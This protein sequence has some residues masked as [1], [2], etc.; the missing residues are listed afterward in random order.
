MMSP[1]QPLKPMNSVPSWKKSWSLKHRLH[2][3]RRRSSKAQR[4]F[5]RRGLVQR[6]FEFLEPRAMMALTFQFNFVKNEAGVGFDNPDTELV[7]T[8]TAALNAA[9]ATFGSWFTQ[10]ATLTIDVQDFHDGPLDSDG[11]PI[12][13]VLNTDPG[14]VRT[15]PERKV[16]LGEDLN[17]ADADGILYLNWEEGNPDVGATSARWNYTDEVGANEM[18]FKGEVLHNLAHILGFRSQITQAGE[19]IFFDPLIH[20]PGEPG[21]W[22]T[23]DTFLSDSPL[24]EG[25][26]L[27][28]PTTFRLDLTRWGAAMIGGNSENTGL[29]FHGP[30]A[31]E[32]NG[33][34]PVPLLS[35]DP[36]FPGATGSHLRPTAT[37]N[38][39]N[40]MMMAPDMPGAQ[41]LGLQARRFTP[42]EVGMM[43]DLGYV[44][45]TTSP[46][47]TL[48]TTR[49]SPTP[50]TSA[51][52][53]SVDFGEAVMGSLS[54][55]DIE[56]INATVSNVVQAGTLFRFTV[57]PTVANG[58]V[59]LRIPG[60]AM[61]DTAGNLSLASDPLMIVIDSTAPS[62]VLS[63]GAVSPT[64]SLGAFSVS[65]N[66]SESLPQNMT[67]GQISVS[68]GVVSDLQQAGN[69]VTF[70]VTPSTAN[71][72]VSVVVP[73]E[74]LTDAAGNKNVA[75]NTISVVIDTTRPTPVFV[76]P[77]TSSSEPKVTLTVNFGETVGDFLIDPPVT[78]T[79]G[80]VS[81]FA[82]VTL[83]GIP[84]SG[85]T[86]DVTPDTP[87]STVVVSV[88]ADAIDD[89]AGN[90]NVGSATPATI[91]FGAATTSQISGRV[92]VDDNENGL[93]NV[94]ERTLGGVTVE[95]FG[96]T[97]GLR[98]RIVTLA[99]GSYRFLN[100]PQGE[101]RVQFSVPEFY[102]D[103]PGPNQRM[104]TITAPG[105]QI[106]GQDFALLGLSPGYGSVLENLA[107][108]FYR[109]DASLRTRG[110]VAVVKADGS[111]G[112]IAIVG[113]FDGV[114]AVELVLSDDRSTAYVTF[115]TANLEV[116][117]ATVDR[118]KLVSITDPSGNRLIRLLGGISDLTFTSVN[119]DAPPVG[120]ARKYFESIEKVFEQE[121]WGT[122]GSNPSTTVAPVIVVSKNGQTPT[123]L[124]VTASGTSTE[125]DVVLNAAPV[126]GVVVLNVQ[127]ANTNHLQITSP[128]GAGTLTFTAANWNIPQKV[129][130]QGKH[131]GSS[132]V[133]NQVTSVAIGV[134]ASLTTATN[135]RSTLPQSVQVTTIDDMGSGV[136]IAT[137]KGSAGEGLSIGGAIVPLSGFTETP[138]QAALAAGDVTGDGV[139]DYLVQAPEQY[140]AV[141]DGSTQKGSILTTLGLAIG[142][143]THLAVIEDQDGDRINDVVAIST[144]HGP[145]LSIFSISQQRAIRVSQL[146]S[147]AIGLASGDFD[148]DGKDDIVTIESVGGSNVIRVYQGDLTSRAQLSPSFQGYVTVASGDL[149][150]D[151]KAEILVGQ[152]SQ[153]GSRVLVFS[154]GT[155]ASLAS[156][157]PFAGFTSDLRL[158]VDS[159]TRSIV[160]GMGS[161]GSTIGT[162]SLT[163]ESRGTSSPF[164]TSSLGVQVA[165]ARSLPTREVPIPRISFLSGRQLPLDSNG[166]Y[167]A[168]SSPIRLVVTFTPNVTGFTASDLQIAGGSMVEGSFQASSAFAT[169]AV[170]STSDGVVSIDIPE[171]A[172]TG[173]GGGLPSGRLP[174]PF[175]I[176]FDPT[177]PVPVV[178]LPG[179]SNETS[180]VGTIRFQEDVPGLFDGNKVT[181]T[182]GTVTEVTRT[183]MATFQFRLTPTNRGQASTVTVAPNMVFDTGGLGNVAATA[184]MTFASSSAPAMIPILMSS[185]GE[186]TTE[187][188]IPFEVA[189]GT[190][191]TGFTVS[192]PVVTN[193]TV[194]AGS[195]EDLG[196]GR[197]RFEVNPTAAGAVTV[198]IPANAVTDAANATRQ[199]VA[200]GVVSIAYHPTAAKPEFLVEGL[201][202]GG[203]SS[204]RRIPFAV[205][206]SAPVDGFGLEDIR[207]TG[208]RIENFQGEESQPDYVFE[209]VSDG[210]GEIS[211]DIPAG[212]AKDV[213]LVDSLPSETFTF[214]SV[215]A[216]DV[217]IRLASDPT[218]VL[219]G[220]DVYYLL[221]VSNVGAGTV[222][223]VTATATLPPEFTY[224]PI[225]GLLADARVTGSGQVVTINIGDLVADREQF[226]TIRTRLASSVTVN[227]V[228][229][230]TFAVTGGNDQDAT[231]NSA[232]FSKTVV[233]GSSAPGT[234]A[235]VQD[236]VNGGNV[237]V[238][239]PAD[240]GAT[241]SNLVST[242]IL[243]LPESGVAAAALPIGVEI[244]ATSF[245]VNLAAGGKVVV[246]LVPPNGVPTNASFSKYGKLPGQTTPTV[247]SFMYDA[248]TDLGAK[249]YPDRIEIHLQDGKLGDD[250][251]VANGVI[252]DPGFLTTLNVVRPYQFLVNPLDVNGDGVVRPLDALLILNELN[253]V[254]A[255]PLPDVVPMPVTKFAFWDTNGDAFV[256]PIDVLL[257]IN[258]LNSGTDGE[259]EQAE[260]GSEGPLAM[261][262][263]ASVSSV[264][265]GTRIGQDG[266]VSGGAS[267]HRGEAFVAMVG[268]RNS[269]LDT[270]WVAMERKP[271]VSSKGDSRV[272]G[273]EGERESRVRRASEIVGW[274]WV[275]GDS[276]AESE[277]SREKW[278]AELG[279]GCALED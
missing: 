87:T 109:I 205:R 28:D 148:G 183:G 38:R 117:T 243:A 88:K 181:A 106:E 102:V 1:R 72:T 203:T 277:S 226:F 263:A 195:I 137:G 251:G 62:V 32:A 176:R 211:L 44:L 58:A 213:D 111:L 192:K 233:A 271:M 262:G 201:V 19:D 177:A 146:D 8:R 190:P 26:P 46:K 258:L 185:A 63:S 232:T 204:L 200:S 238:S 231:N 220:A 168:K 144:S 93:F 208:G 259:G 135:Y 229:S 82:D 162:F 25:S 66:L 125:F 256:S 151:G 222:T 223:G 103:A 218:T 237:T 260:L 37:L 134:N 179:T 247:Y 228:Q 250:D 9:A 56:S 86:F 136:I 85:I 264:S 51:F 65:A 21:T 278:F 267:S 165:V 79:G 33:G 167:V 274:S 184:T 92:Y 52:E 89:L 11:A 120:R 53:V 10:T 128:S 133:L 140:M 78:I 42:V 214:R 90:L 83:N 81:N 171:G 188:P 100:V 101:Y 70:M 276:E 98:R 49:P 244:A 270:G 114:R 158:A 40:S 121:G 272:G 219:A 34:E 197:Y 129:V 174:A 255:H 4:S 266:L 95:L 273:G 71:G 43:R 236:A 91:V 215:A 14:F 189:F 279:Q 161:G 13:A 207:I 22:A 36:Y 119:L 154:G 253:S 194:R 269:R 139:T 105:S 235:T 16:Q 84:N 97:V 241:V 224:V 47:P 202:R 12:I 147:S 69:T 74:A 182:N 170:Q 206:F 41:N 186:S 2:R 152:S 123:S 6:G 163:G 67:A 61:T 104:V 160:V 18:D 124:A 142:S 57:T 145:K 48:T 216:G 175:R 118:R 138:E 159:V 96:A 54:L 155:G 193:G 173:A 157:T 209:V 108:S 261:Q 64:N 268:G 249:M 275:E 156:F 153:Q 15:V 225:T 246:T 199:N 30:Q 3:G 76:S 130:V 242:P 110:L 221:T 149:N 39:S 50:L 5:V 45:D 257:V 178:E 150:G 127:P 107:S 35:P 80:T 122:V 198:T 20:A 126:G 248:N 132:E 94:G 164:G 131:D 7:A 227:S 24:A 75:S 230:I 141:L 99:D 212:S 116:K 115:V 240:S 169:F 17:G 68:N 23:Y 252:I 180:V 187:S 27:I 210:T 191:V 239:V 166:D 77:P 59:E 31:M 234:S 73:A 60:G 172:A 254:G 143:A 245:Q 113:G 29:F 217:M 112:S 55:D 265:S 196:G